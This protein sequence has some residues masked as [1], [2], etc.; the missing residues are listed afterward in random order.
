M[1]I[2]DPI[3]NLKILEISDDDDEDDDDKDDD[4]ND[5]DNY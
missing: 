2:D 4:D 1:N 5:E 3:Q